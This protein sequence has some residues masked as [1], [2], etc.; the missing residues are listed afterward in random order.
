MALTSFMGLRW[1]VLTSF[2]TQGR[3]LLTWVGHYVELR[4]S[5]ITSKYFETFNVQSFFPLLQ[6][7]FLDIATKLH[8]C[9]ALA[10]PML[11]ECARRTA[12]DRYLSA[13]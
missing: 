7:E 5:S 3:T 13:G 11:D 6:L 8:C 12:V 9:I 10:F 1:P 4:R 2:G